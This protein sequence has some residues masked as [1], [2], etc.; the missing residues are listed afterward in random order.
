MPLLVIAAAT[1]RRFVPILAG[2]SAFLALSI[3]FFKCSAPRR[4]SVYMSRSLT[5]VDTTLL[6]AVFNCGLFVWH[7]SVLRSEAR[8]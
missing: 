4:A 3:I 6:L 1:R 2:V 7:A 5:L 8:A